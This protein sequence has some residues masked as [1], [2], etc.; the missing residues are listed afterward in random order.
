MKKFPFINLRSVCI[1]FMLMFCLVSVAGEKNVGLRA[2]YVT[3]N[4]APSAGLFFKYSFVERFRVAAT[5]DY[6][7]RHNNTDAYSINLN[8]EMPF[9]IIPGKLNVYPLLGVGMTSWNVKNALVEARSYDDSTTR[10]TRMGVNVGVGVD[11]YVTSSLK[12]GLECKYGW[13]KNYAAEITSL[14]IGYVF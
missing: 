12:L 4:N 10:T 5:F 2:G 1:M 8:A 14:S 3:K 11:F 7:F 9:K 13:V 6:Y